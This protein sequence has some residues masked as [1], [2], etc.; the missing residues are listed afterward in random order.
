MEKLKNVEFDAV[1]STIEFHP[2]SK[3]V[4]VRKN[5]LLPDGTC[6]KFENVYSL[7]TIPLQVALEIAAA[8]VKQVGL[9]DYVSED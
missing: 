7:T 6:K 1:V 3:E 9:V 5:Y 4:V 2:A 8:E